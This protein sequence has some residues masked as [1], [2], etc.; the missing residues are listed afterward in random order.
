MIPP[1]YKL[2]EAVSDRLKRRVFTARVSRAGET[3]RRASIIGHK[4]EGDGSQFPEWISA[5]YY[6]PEQL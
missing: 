4:V 5:A 2:E 6:I 1:I 3:P